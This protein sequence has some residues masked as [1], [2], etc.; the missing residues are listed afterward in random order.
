MIIDDG[1][2]RAR[3]EVGFNPRLLPTGSDT[4]YV[5]VERP[6]DWEDI[7]GEEFTVVYA[8][9]PGTA[10]RLMEQFVAEAQDALAE[11]RRNIGD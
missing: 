1:S 3:F 5:S 2:Y 9:D 8:P 6:T 7:P 4:W 11:L 10:L